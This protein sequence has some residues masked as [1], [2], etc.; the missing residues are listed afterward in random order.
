MPNDIINGPD[1]IR[2]KQNHEDHYRLVNG[3]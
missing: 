3:F 2:I 1:E